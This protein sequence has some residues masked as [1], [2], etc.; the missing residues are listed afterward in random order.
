M[1]L[2]E[3]RG[4]RT[5]VVA[6]AVIAGGLV[7]CVNT[8]PDEDLRITT[9]VPVAKLSA[10]LLWKDFQDDAVAARDRYWGK[11]VEITGV[12]THVSAE[13]APRPLVTFAQQ[14]D[15]GIK[16]RLIADRAPEVIGAAKVG[17]RLTLKCF[18]EEMTGGDLVLR[19]CIKP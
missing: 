8:L 18:C 13:G 10:A 5:M 14:D 7:S 19:S 11:A 12:V 15:F 6:W 3:W 17:E 16:A 4:V 1:T 2:G 9:A